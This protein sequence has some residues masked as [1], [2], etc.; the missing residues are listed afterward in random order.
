VYTSLCQGCQDSPGRHP[1]THCKP[2]IM[3]IAKMPHFFH[4]VHDNKATY[5]YGPMTRPKAKQLNLNKLI[6]LS[7]G[8][9]RK[10]GWNEIFHY[11]DDNKGT[12]R[13]YPM[14][15]QKSKPLN[16]NKLIALPCGHTKKR[17]GYFRGDRS[18]NVIE[19]NCRRKCSFRGFP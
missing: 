6:S 14:T 7:S 10:A 13:H 5:R 19:N 12:Y 3:K 18:R 17:G 1:S 9:S 4:Y 11:V 8:H 15:L 16:L 2:G